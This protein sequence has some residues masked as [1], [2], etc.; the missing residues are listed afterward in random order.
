MKI[1]IGFF[2]S[3]CENNDKQI[4]KIVILFQVFNMYKKYSGSKRWSFEML[5]ESF[6]AE[7]GLKEAAASITGSSVFAFLKVCGHSISNFNVSRFKFTQ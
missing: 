3:E 1:H 2:C 5:S 6:N 7:G 4:K